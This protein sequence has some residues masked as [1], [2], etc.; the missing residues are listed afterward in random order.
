MKIEHRSIKNGVILE[1]FCQIHT[2]CLSQVTSS[3]VLVVRVGGCKFNASQENTTTQNSTKSESRC[4]LFTLSLHENRKSAA[5][6]ILVE[7]FIPSRFTS[8]VHLA[9]A[10]LNDKKP[11]F[12]S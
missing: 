12:G 7:I 2:L 4:C 9:D 6:T 3:L 11:I 10:T 5:G 1:N 8:I